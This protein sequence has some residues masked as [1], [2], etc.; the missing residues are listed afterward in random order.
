V[1]IVRL[2]FG[3]PATCA[4][5]PGDVACC[6]RRQVALS[7]ETPLGWRLTPRHRRAGDK[8]Y[9]LGPIC[10]SVLARVPGASPGPKGD[11][12]QGAEILPGE[13]ALHAGLHRQLAQDFEEHRSCRC[14]KART[15]RGSLPGAPTPRVCCCGRPK[16]I[17][18]EFAADRRVVPSAVGLAAP[19]RISMQGGLDQPANVTP[20]VGLG[21]SDHD[22]CRQIGEALNGQSDGEHGGQPAP[23]LTAIMTAAVAVQPR[24]RTRSVRT[25]CSAAQPCERG[26]SCRFV[27]TA[28][29]AQPGRSGWQR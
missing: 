19:N 13:P 8:R 24:P 17:R 10:L 23:R 1:N 22:G 21:D 6:R 25:A 27:A 28:R 4:R 29:R 14:P 20:Q 7:V 5:R 12:P 18:G 2:H 16:W 9:P 26:C 15:P 3:S 11:A